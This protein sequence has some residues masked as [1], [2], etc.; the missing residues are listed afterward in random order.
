[1]R[2]CVIKDFEGFC[3]P[4]LATGIAPNC[5]AGRGKNSTL[6]SLKSMLR[7]P[8]FWGFANEALNMTVFPLP[9]TRAFSGLQGFAESVQ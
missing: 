2:G 6:L 3:G 1:M 7:E 8:S 5:R 4:A 9:V